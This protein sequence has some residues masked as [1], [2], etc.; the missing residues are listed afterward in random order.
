MS[1][2]HI[3]GLVILGFMVGVDICTRMVKIRQ[4]KHEFDFE[5]RCDIC[6]RNLNLH[7]KLESKDS[8]SL[9][10]AECPEH[11]GNAA[12]LWPQRDDILQT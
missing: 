10:S 5:G 3:T 9:K 1:Y 8:L 12:I 11:L 6:G 7:L 2:I 4:L